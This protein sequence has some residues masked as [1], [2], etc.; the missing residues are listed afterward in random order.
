[1]V[2]PV[3]E[4]ISLP[5]FDIKKVYKIPSEDN[6]KVKHQVSLKDLTCD[7]S[8]FQNYLSKFA[9]DDLRRACRHIRSAIV[10]SDAM[11]DSWLRK[12][13]GDRF[14]H[15]HYFVPDGKD[16]AFGYY[17]DNPWIAY[18]GKW[19]TTRK[20][21][22]IYYNRFGYS[23]V[24]QRWASNSEPMDASEIVLMISKYFPVSDAQRNWKP[25]WPSGSIREVSLTFSLT[26]NS[27]KEVK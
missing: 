27:I 1:M 14:I 25:K 5:S 26:G 11:A 8:D 16:C 9:K 12:L 18:Y 23:N 22:K 15:E 10:I 13:I 17:L 24:E 6:S 21:S 19:Y 3:T 4:I 20:G 7:C 2:Y